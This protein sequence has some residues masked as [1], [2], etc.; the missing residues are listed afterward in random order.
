MNYD[1]KFD[2]IKE[3]WISNYLGLEKYSYI[4]DEL[5]KVD[6][7]TDI[8]YQTTFN[9]FYK[10][11]RDKK[12]RKVYYDYFEKNKNNDNLTFEQVIRYLYKKT[13]NIEASFSS[14]LLATI[15][16]KMPIWDQYVIKNLK[17]SLSGNTKEEQLKNAIDLYDKIVDKYNCL[18]QRE[19]IKIVINQLNC[20]LKKYKMEDTKI[21]DFILWSIR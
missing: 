21:L 13:G 19:D 6:I 5:K 3:N 8:N 20:I 16:P 2:E 4:I 18:L 15:N 7:S 12:W 10:I 9:S 14:K 17:L 11:R 1:F